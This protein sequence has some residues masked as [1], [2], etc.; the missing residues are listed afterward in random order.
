MYGEGATCD[1]RLVLFVKSEEE[2]ERER[3]RSLYPNGVIDNKGAGVKSLHPL[4]EHDRVG[5]EKQEYSKAVDHQI[6]I[7]SLV[8]RHNCYSARTL[9]LQISTA[10][11]VLKT[12]HN[13]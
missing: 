9:N 2:R 12:D 6:D 5:E 11:E 8:R 3:E 10:Q 13:K 7:K 1:T 4:K